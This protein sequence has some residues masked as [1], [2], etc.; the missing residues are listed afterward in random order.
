MKVFKWNIYSLQN[1]LEAAERECTESSPKK[2]RIKID[3][4]SQPKHSEVKLRITILIR[5]LD[6]DEG[7]TSRYF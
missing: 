2:I 7:P 4:I 5:V 1:L 6:N 3:F